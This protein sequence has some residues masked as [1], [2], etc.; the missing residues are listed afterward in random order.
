MGNITTQQ[1]NT[2]AKGVKGISQFLSQDNVKAKFQEILGQKANGFI[3]SVLSAVSQNEQLKNSDQNSVYLSAMIAA[4]LDLPIN[5][6]LG[7]AYLV[8]YRGKDGVQVCQFQMGAKGYKQLALRTGQFKTLNDTDV[9][10]GEIKHHNRMTGEIE[11]EWIQ[12]P[13]ERLSKKIVGYLS[14]FKLISGFEHTLYWTVEE[15]E[16]HAKKY[17]QTYKKYGTGLWKDDKHGMSLKTVV[18][19]NLSKNAPMSIE[20]QRAFITDQAVIKNYEP[21]S[22]DTLDVETEYV[23]NNETIEEKIEDQKADMKGKQGSGEQIK[24]DMP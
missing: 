5:P 15:I 6:N 24:A 14:Y 10:E 19:M 12:N 8:P 11:F 17:S 13:E 2:P 1:N 3:A 9:R 4:S 7:F 20:L 22:E 21:G 16:A 23:D 18:K